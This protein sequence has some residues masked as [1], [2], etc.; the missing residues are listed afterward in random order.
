LRRAFEALV[1]TFDRLAVDY[2]GETL[3]EGERGN[4]GLAALVFERL[5][6]AGEPECDQA[7]MGGMICQERDRKAGTRCSANATWRQAATPREQTNVD[8]E[9]VENV[10]SG[11]YPAGTGL[12]HARLDVCALSCL[13]ASYKAA[14]CSSNYTMMA[15]IVASRASDDG[16]L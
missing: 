14:R 16:T 15:G 13:M 3:L 9:T 5:R 8:G 7:I 10:P 4:I 12:T 2:H 11:L 1:L 6:H